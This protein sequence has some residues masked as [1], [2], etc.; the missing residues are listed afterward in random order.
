MVPNQPS[1]SIRMAEPNDVPAIASVLC[2]SFAEYQ[3]FYTPAAFAATTPTADAIRRR[4]DEGPVWVAYNEGAVVGTVS[5]V[6]KGVACYIRSMAALPAD[7]GH[8]IGGLLLE[9]IEDFAAAQGLAYLLLSTTP[10]LTHAIRLYE[11]VGFQRNGEGPHDLFGTPLFTMV[12]PLG[13]GE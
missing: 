11:R 6:P 13:H 10:F 5:A 7:R 2:E 3:P 4:L 9:H 1:I 8:G 12:K